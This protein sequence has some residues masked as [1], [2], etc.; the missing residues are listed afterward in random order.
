[1]KKNLFQNGDFK[2]A[3]RDWSLQ[4]VSTLDSNNWVT[5]TLSSGAAGFTQSSST[6]AEALEGR[7]SGK[8]AKGA[9][10]YQRQGFQSEVLQVDKELQGNVVKF[11]FSYNLTQVSGT[12]SLTGVVTTHDI[13]IAIYD[14]TNSAWIQPSGHMAINSIGIAAIAS[15]EFQLPI[16]TAQVKMFIYQATTSTASWSIVADSFQLGKVERVYG[17]V[18]TD[19]QTFTPTGSWVSNASY[20]GKWMRVGDTIK[21]QVLVSLTGAPTAVGLTVNLPSGLTIDT[22]KQASSSGEYFRGS[23]TIVDASPAT[24]YTGLT[25]YQASTTAVGL[26]MSDSA[27]AYTIGSNGVTHTQPITFANGDSVFLTYEAPI[28][29][30]S[31]STVVSSDADARVVAASAQGAGTNAMTTGT[32]Y[33]LAMTTA[34]F[35]TH[36]AQTVSAATNGTTTKSGWYYTAKIPGYYQVTSQISTNGANLAANSY[37]AVSLRKNG[38]NQASM[39]IVAASGTSQYS[40]ITGTQTV[41]LNAGDYVELAFETSVS[42]I[43]LANNQGSSVSIIK[44]QGPATI[45]AST[46]VSASSKNSSSQLITNSTVT[47]LTGWTIDTNS[48]GS[49]ATNGEFTAPEPGEYEAKLQIAYLASTGGVRNARIKLNGTDV[50]YVEIPGGLGGVFG[51][52]CFWQGKLLPGDKLRPA[53]FQSSGASINISS[54]SNFNKW[55]VNKIGNY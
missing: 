50:S 51:V 17:S 12:L 54:D 46:K 40:A 16:N 43:T 34:N 14:I 47:D 33:I 53:T 44:V 15:G 48:H 11:E 35:D 45:A 41:F 38:S 10:N 23:A 19:W 26:R 24:N 7:T 52:S 21:V 37:V 2:D 28:S 32:M 20:S 36:G 3:M 29:G 39:G 9:A 18:V 5:G 6:T 49:Q 31:S 13:K 27:G 25:C 8:W 1:M 42:S 55:V 22:S 4:T 30:W